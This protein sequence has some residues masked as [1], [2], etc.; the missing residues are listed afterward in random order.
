[1]MST[2]TVNTDEKGVVIA[3]GHV[4]HCNIA[5]KHSVNASELPDDIRE[6]LGVYHYIDGVFE[7]VTIIN[8]AEER[9]WQQTELAR[10][11]A[12]IA[13]YQAD[14]TIDER[15]SELRAG[16][17]TEEDY[18]KLLG[19]RKLLIEYV[20]QADFPECGRPKLSASVR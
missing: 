11:N 6:H 9:Y 10:V 20:Q 13:E 3:I 18:F 8:E 14:I 19:D 5:H 16:T 12:A 7:K 17:Y 2:V 4:T 15:Y 1:M